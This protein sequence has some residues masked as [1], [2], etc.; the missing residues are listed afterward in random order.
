[1]DEIIK[2]L[3]SAVIAYVVPK[4]LSGIEEAVKPVGET[5][6][7]LPWAQWLAACFIGG[8]FGGALSGAIGEQG[9]GNWAVY[10]AAIGVMQWFALRGYLP[11]GGWWALASALGWASA[12]LFVFTP[13]GGCFVG[14][15]VGVLQIVGLK[16][17]GLLWWVG[18]NAVAWGAAGILTP[19]L[20]KFIGGAFGFAL[21]WIIGWGIIAAISALFLL[22]PLARLV[23]EKKTTK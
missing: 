9:A 20:A 5:E 2:M 23:P 6:R 18:G 11:V 22:L 15:A 4:A 19:P 8:A 10:G 3:A 13:F 14:L 21:G 7:N 16:A 1:M 12:P 17:K